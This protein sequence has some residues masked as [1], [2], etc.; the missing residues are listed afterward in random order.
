MTEMRLKRYDKALAAVS[1]MEAQQPKDPTVQNLKGGVYLAKGDAASAR[2]ALKKRSRCRPNYFPAVANLAQLEMKEKKPEVASKHLTAFLE[3]N[4]KSV[5][6]MAGLAELAQMQGKPAEVTQWRE[7]AQAEN[8]DA[9]LPAMLLGAH[10]LRTGAKDKALTLVRKFQVANPKNPELLDLLGQ[11]QM[12]NG[13]KDGALESY[14]KLTATVAEIGAGADAPG[15]G[16]HDAEQPECGRRRPEEGAGDR[17]ILRSKPSWR[18]PSW[19]CAAASRTRRWPWRARSRS[20]VRKT[21][22]ASCWKAPCCS[23]R[24]RTRWRCA[25]MNRRWRCRAARWP[26]PSCTAR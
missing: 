8:P 5:E 1:A 4:P 7:K 23:R 2:A 18:R 20:S 24:A 17:S 12:A 11:A 21:R 26:R 15:T 25:R 3:K 14:S 6:A 19:R 10:Y 9:V 22:P 13:D 16:P